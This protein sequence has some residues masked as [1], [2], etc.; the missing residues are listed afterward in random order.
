M[1]K[2]KKIRNTIKTI[3]HPYWI[4][5]II[6]VGIWISA[7]V[8][9]TVKPVP[10]DIAVSILP[11]EKTGDSRKYLLEIRKGP[12]KEVY[13]YNKGKPFRYLYGRLFS[14]DM[15]ESCPLFIDIESKGEFDKMVYVVDNNGRLFLKTSFCKEDIYYLVLVDEEEYHYFYYYQQVDKEKSSIDTIAPG[16]MTGNPAPVP[17]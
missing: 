13:I 5:P 3:I 8:K 12:D 1:T 10:I 4:I 6:I 11:D 16:N 15:K 17:M 2:E 7:W 14:K 9:N